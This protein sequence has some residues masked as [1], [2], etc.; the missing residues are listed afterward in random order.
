[1]DLD[2]EH[3]RETLGALQR[4]RVALQFALDK[5]NNA[6]NALKALDAAADPLDPRPRRASS[7]PDPALDG[8]SIPDAAERV[9]REVQKPMHVYEIITRLQQR[10]YRADQERESLRVSVV[11]SLARKA[12]ARETFV[13]KGAGTYGLR[14]WES[15]DDLDDAAT[16]GEQSEM[17]DLAGSTNG[18]A[19]EGGSTP[20]AAEP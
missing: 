5:V 4:R 7:E 13:G 14:E 19:A 18:S 16:A 10:G 20:S 11:G 9:L 2:T 3:F 17:L 12:R 6:I 15:Q 1:M 8:L